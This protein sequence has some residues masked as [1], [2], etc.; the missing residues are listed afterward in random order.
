MCTELILAFIYFITIFL[1]NY[2]LLQLLKNNIETISY[3]LKIENLLT[4]YSSTEQ[5]NLFYY[6]IQFKKKIKTVQMFYYLNGLLETEDLL[7]IGNTYKF[8][9][10]NA[11]K[12]NVSLMVSEKNENKAFFANKLY[13]R[14]L[15]NQY[16]SQ[17]D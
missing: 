12:E 4:Y 15:E 17:K 1:V 5:K 11:K 10:K 9:V 6:L 14:L 2:F 16:L 13:F 3:L 7:I 8:L